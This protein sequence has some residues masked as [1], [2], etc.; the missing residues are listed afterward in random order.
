MPYEIIGKVFFWI[1]FTF[2]MLCLISVVLRGL[3]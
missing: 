2:G 3:D 1:I